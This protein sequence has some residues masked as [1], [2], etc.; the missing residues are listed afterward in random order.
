MLI[1]FRQLPHRSIRG[2]IHIGAH[3]AEELNDYVSCGINRVL[4]VEANP[5]LYPRLRRKLAIYPQMQLGEF[6]AG[7][8]TREGELNIA[9]NGQSSS[10][11]DLGT[12]Q[13]DHPD[14]T[15]IATTH[16]RIQP[17][18]LWLEQLEIDRS[19]YNFLNLDV[20][21]YEL[22]A[23]KGLNL[24]LAHV[25]YVYTEVNSKEVYRACAQLADMDHYL[26]NHGLFRVAT[27]M[28]DHGWGDA[29]YARQQRKRLWLKFQ[30]QNGFQ[31]I[32]HAAL[33]PIRALWRSRKGQRE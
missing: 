1:P 6:A 24:Q 14:V 9:N 23:L 25:D 11:L 18:D 13:Q 20:Q 21:G 10:L 30:L 17:V 22:S 31:R 32:K 7:E 26:A 27:A 16:V 28:T 2:I 12:H 15:F 29:L 33:L 4:W 19:H 3:E 5:D 8:T